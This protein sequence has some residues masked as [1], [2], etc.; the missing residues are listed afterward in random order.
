MSAPQSTDLEMHLRER[1]EGRDQ[2]VEVI[3]V[4]PSFHGDSQLS[5]GPYKGFTREGQGKGIRILFESDLSKKDQRLLLQE[6]MRMSD[7]DRSHSSEQGLSLPEVFECMQTEP[8]DG[9]AL[10]AFRKY[11]SGISL[12][13]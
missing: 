6:A 10:E 5:N 12:Q 3:D 7:Q 8:D 1:R 9:R 13:L 2:L 4:Y 11:R